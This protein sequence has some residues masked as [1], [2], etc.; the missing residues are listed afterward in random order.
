[1][2]RNPFSQAFSWRRNEFSLDRNACRPH[3]TPPEHSNDTARDN[4]SPDGRAKKNFTDCVGRVI[5]MDCLLTSVG[6]NQHPRHELFIEVLL[7]RMGPP[8]ITTGAL[9]SQVS[10]RHCL[11][12]YHWFNHVLMY[13]ASEVSFR[14]GLVRF[15]HIHVWHSP[16]YRQKLRLPM[17]DPAQPRSP[18]RP[19]LSLLSNARITLLARSKVPTRSGTFIRGDVTRMIPGWWVHVTWASASLVTAVPPIRSFSSLLLVKYDFSPI[20]ATILA[21]RVKQLPVRA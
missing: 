11:I 1:M 20:L 3:S 14:S 17:Q 21:L 9:S 2:L 18:P 12:S 4:G 15:W 6:R 5:Q 7:A 10:R 13:L 19:V 16:S 8:F